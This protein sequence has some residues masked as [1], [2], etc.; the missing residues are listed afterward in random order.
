MLK[1]DIEEFDI[2]PSDLGVNLTFM[3]VS[4]MS[5]YFSRLTTYLSNT[6]IN[7]IRSL[8]KMPGTAKEMS[9]VISA[10]WEILPD[11]LDVPNSPLYIEGL[12]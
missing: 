8:S 2:N 12:L 7:R 6:A 4:D 3:G 10:V 11:E 9:T 1:I 5:E